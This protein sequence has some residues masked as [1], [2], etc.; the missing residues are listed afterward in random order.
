MANKEKPGKKRGFAAMSVAQR[1]R[2]ASLGGKAAHQQGKAHVF[3]S[4]EA[5]EAGKKGGIEAHRRGTAHRFTSAQA[6][7]AGKKGKK[8]KPSQRTEPQDGP[9]PGNG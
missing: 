8:P 2:I 3:T 4:D 1:K 6:R 5:A 7:A 9:D